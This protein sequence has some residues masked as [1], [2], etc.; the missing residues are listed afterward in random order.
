MMNASNPP[1]EPRLRR[2]FLAALDIT[3]LYVFGTD[4]CEKI[5]LHN[6]DSFTGVIYAPNA[7]V[8]L[9]AGSPKY[10][11]CHVFGAISG[12]KVTL[13]KNV[14]FHYD[15]NVGETPGFRLYVIKSWREL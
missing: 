2:L 7:E 6:M 9:K 5:E 12:L 8:K 4:K 14:D 11:H 10:Y 13:E 1:P 15:E 3:D